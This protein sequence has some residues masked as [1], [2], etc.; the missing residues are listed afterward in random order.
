M[1]NT[2]KPKLKDNLANMNIKE[3]RHIF[4]ESSSMHGSSS[5]RERIN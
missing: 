5:N 1:D 4:P 2:Y 3:L